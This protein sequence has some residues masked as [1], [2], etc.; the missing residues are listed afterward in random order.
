M[1]FASSGTKITYSLTAS[2]DNTA[3]F[4]CFLVSV[5]TSALD[6]SLPVPDVVGTAISPKI[7]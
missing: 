5:T 3:N 7:R 1:D 2:S 4:S 6:N